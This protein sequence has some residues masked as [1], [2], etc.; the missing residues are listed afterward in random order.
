M[1][2]TIEY[3]SS[4]HSYSLT[5]D[6]HELMKFTHH[7][8]ACRCLGFSPDGAR[9]FTGS[10][11]KSLCAIDMERGALVHKIKKAHRCEI[12]EIRNI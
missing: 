5:E 4:S 11:D 9:L 3:I 8:K 7:K 6:N 2:N 12:L 1:L 10:K